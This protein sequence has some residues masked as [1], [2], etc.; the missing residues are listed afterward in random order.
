L[1]V[2]T[3]EVGRE[4]IGGLLDANLGARVGLRMGKDIESRLLLGQNGAENLRGNGDL[5]FKDIGEPIRL[6]APFLPKDR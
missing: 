1:I 4:T 5:L 2:A 6:Q 3:Q